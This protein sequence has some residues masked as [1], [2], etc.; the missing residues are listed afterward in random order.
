MVGTGNVTVPNVA[1]RPQLQATRALQDDGFRVTTRERRDQT[2]PAGSA[3]E[4][5]PPAGNVIPRGSEVEL[6]VSAGR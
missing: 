4:T 2:A 3:I 6:T 1:G 5:R